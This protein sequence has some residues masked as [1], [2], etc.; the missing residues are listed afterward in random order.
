MAGRSE[1]FWRKSTRSS[2][3][4]CVEIAVSADTGLV[5]IRD[6]WNPEGPV[7]EF[8]PAV[9]GAF[10]AELKDAGPPR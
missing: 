7:L 4:N 1:L 5:L 6:S 2:S 8:E 3:G 9:F 10:I